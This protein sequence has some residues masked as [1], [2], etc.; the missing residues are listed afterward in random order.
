MYLSKDRRSSHPATPE[1]RQQSDRLDFRGK[2]V[3][4][5]VRTAQSR[6][7][8]NVSKIN[9]NVNLN[10]LE[11]CCFSIRNHEMSALAN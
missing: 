4:V 5:A 8:D 7:E 10:T 2:N 9:P 6:T 3:D 1:E 11:Y